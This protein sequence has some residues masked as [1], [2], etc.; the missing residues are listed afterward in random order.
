[1][2]N[3]TMTTALSLHK[4]EGGWCQ[5]RVI[6]AELP[7][8][9]PGERFQLHAGNHW[10]DITDVRLA[11]E[12]LIYCGS[13]AFRADYLMAIPCRITSTPEEVAA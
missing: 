6:K 9:L 2:S 1:M 12:V 8:L 3:P 7:N 13:T 4:P 10:L 5:A 11:P